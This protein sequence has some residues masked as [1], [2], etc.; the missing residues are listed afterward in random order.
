MKQSDIL[1][2]FEIQKVRVN[3]Q[4]TRDFRETL[5]I[6]T[7]QIYRSFLLSSYIKKSQ[8]INIYKI[9]NFLSKEPFSVFKKFRAN[10]WLSPLPALGWRH[11]TTGPGPLKYVNSNVDHVLAECTVTIAAPKPIRSASNLP[12]LR[13]YIPYRW[14]RTFL[15]WLIPARPLVVRSLLN[16]TPATCPIDPSNGA[17]DNAT[18]PVYLHVKPFRPPFLPPPHFPT[19]C[20]FHL[21]FHFRPSAFTDLEGQNETS[22]PFDPPFVF[23]F[24]FPAESCFDA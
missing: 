12:E 11:D 5:P 19:V 7:R 20:R 22:P 23:S 4:S 8:W 9:Y 14:W 2:Q 13:R 6:I 10:R 17:A 1:I 24:P 15:C 21:R 16:Y 18:L 3:N